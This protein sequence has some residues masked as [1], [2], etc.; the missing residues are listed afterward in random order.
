MTIYFLFAISLIGICVLAY[1]I[2]KDKKLL[3]KYSSIADAEK[4]AKR[5]REES[6]VLSKKVTELKGEIR[7]LEKSLQLL[8]EEE[9]LSDYAFYENKYNFQNLVEIERKLTEVR[10][11][12]KNMIKD[13]SAATCSTQWT[14]EGN[15]S[16]GRKMVNN[17]IK[18]VLRAFNG[19]CDA[20]VLKVNYKNIVTLEKRIEKAYETLNGL[21]KDKEI[22]ISQ[23]YLELKIEELRLIHEFQEK[24]Q[25]EKEEQKRIKEIM[26]EEEQARR[27]L[28]KAKEDSEKEELRYKLALEKA[29]KEIETTEGIKRQKL[30]EQIKI[31]EEQLK[32]ASLRKERA[33]SRAQMTKSGHVYVISNVGSFGKNV[34]KIGMTRRLEPIDRVKELSSASVPFPFD[35]HAMIYSN[36][37][38]ELENRLHKIFHK[39]QLNKAN[40]KK[41]F[42][43]I[44]LES[45]EQIV[46]KLGCNVHFTRIY[47]AKEFRKSLAIAKKNILETNK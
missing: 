16:K 32:E 28:E 45:I 14:V 40:D 18:L 31:L 41:E 35:V 27:E 29:Q 24:K 9:L 26:R 46:K 10:E 42:F 1:I 37:A 8:R 17:H 12:Q 7:N 47:E 3:I 15:K 22:T 20:A 36:N 4:E 21:S 2:Y 44:R 6:K 34:Y 43:R 5:I 30:L 23:K 19:E 25:E 33:I 38:P 11:I 39:F 13:K